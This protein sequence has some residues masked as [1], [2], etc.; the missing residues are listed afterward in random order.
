MHTLQHFKLIEPYTR[1][2]RKKLLS[3]VVKAVSK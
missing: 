2:L 1:V 3:K